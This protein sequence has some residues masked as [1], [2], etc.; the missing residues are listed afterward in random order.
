[1]AVERATPYYPTG[2]FARAH[3]QSFNPEEF[4]ET[5]FDR[6]LRTN[7]DRRTFGEL[8]LRGAVAG[9][10]LLFARGSSK[11]PEIGL[12]RASFLELRSQARRDRVLHDATEDPTYFD[13]GKDS[14]EE[15]AEANVLFDSERDIFIVAHDAHHARRVIDEGRLSDQTFD[16]V[17]QKII[18]IGKKPGIDL[19]GFHTMREMDRLMDQINAIVPSDTQFLLSSRNYDLLDEVPAQENMIKMYSVGEEDPLTNFKNLITGRDSML[20]D[21]V[22]NHLPLADTRGELSMCGLAVEKSI[23][24]Q[25]LIRGCRQNGMTSLVWTVDDPYQMTKFL[26][27]G[28]TIMNSNRRDLLEQIGADSQEALM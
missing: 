20:E 4:L 17:V 24:T 8:A 23:M 22:Y 3:E 15:I 16:T 14:P 19:K 9:S 10:I 7:M 28:V 27:W 6:M 26:Q 1:M 12:D 13:Y 5:P 21:V 2:E 25:S 18:D 11:D